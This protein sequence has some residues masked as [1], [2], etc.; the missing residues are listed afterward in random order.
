VSRATI[1][2]EV[3]LGDLIAVTLNPRL[4]RP[5]SLVYPK[6]K[7]RSRL[8]QTFLDCVVSTLKEPR[9]S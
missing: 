4:N 1:L 6:E 5:L 2:K 8:L 3:K 9:Q 7:F